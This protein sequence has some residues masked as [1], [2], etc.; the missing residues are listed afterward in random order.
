MKA[1]KINRNLYPGNIFITD[2]KNI[3]IVEEL[4]A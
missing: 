4:L 3:M 1:E 2:V